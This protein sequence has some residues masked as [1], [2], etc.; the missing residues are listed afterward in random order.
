MNKPTVFIVSAKDLFNK[1]KNPKMSLSLKDI[2]Q[3]D[4]IPKS[5]P[6]GCFL[7]NNGTYKWIAESLRAYGSILLAWTDNHGTQYDI[8]FTRNP[9]LPEGDRVRRCPYQGGIH[10]YELF[11]S[12]MRI[13]AWGFDCN[14]IKKYPS[15]I[16]E[17]LAGGRNLGVTGE[18]LAKLINGVIKYVINEPNENK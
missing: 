16:E 5:T 1:R 3:I 11:V 8:L 10:G 9:F 4:A 2:W 13:G 17:K 12:I 6:D 7:N 18:E 14:E 15:Y